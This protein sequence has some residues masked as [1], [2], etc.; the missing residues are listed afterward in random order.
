MSIHVS[1]HVYIYVHIYFE[2]VRKMI[3]LNRVLNL[4]RYNIYMYTDLCICKCAYVYV[5]HIHLFKDT[6]MGTV[7]LDFLS[8]MASAP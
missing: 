1:V 4:L 5:M 6:Y 7:L 3:I 2:N 8:F